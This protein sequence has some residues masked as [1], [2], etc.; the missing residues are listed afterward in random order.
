[1]A[2][3]AGTQHQVDMAEFLA[4][5][6]QVV[7]DGNIE[8]LKSPCG[9][10]DF[11]KK[12]SLSV[13]RKQS[14]AFEALRS[15]EDPHVAYYLLRWSANASRMNYLSRTTPSKYCRTALESFDCE[16]RQTFVGVSGLALDDDQWTQATFKP[17]EGG[18][19]LRSAAAVADAAYLGSRSDTHELCALIREGWTWDVDHMDSFLEQASTQVNAMLEASGSSQRCDASQPRLKQSIVGKMIETAR[20][21]SWDAAQSPDAQCRR[22]AYS[23]LHAG[24]VLG[25]TPSLTL[26]KCLSKSDFAISVACRLGV[27]VCEGDVPCNFCG[28]VMDRGGRHCL[29][30]MAGGDHTLQH[31]D[32]RNIVHSFCERA[33]LRPEREAGGILAT[34]P[35]PETR[36]RPADVLVCSSAI[37]AKTLPDGTL[38]RMPP[39]MALDFTVVNA[40][41]RGHWRETLGEAGAA[42]TSY[43]E[44]KRAYRNTA[45][46]CEEA[47]VRF[48]PIVFEAQ[49]GMTKEAAAVLHTL[50]NAVAQNENADPRKMKSDIIQRIGLALARHVASAIKR[51]RVPRPCA[52]AAACQRELERSAILTV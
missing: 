3:A 15:L 7:G 37:F 44:T 30:C 22:H 23:G 33:R 34:L 36:R 35:N 46:R 31:N 24:K 39:Q 18:L 40:L 25:V 6:C 17:R 27:D 47:G 41:G 5:G 16:V 32:V 49:G 8:V 45:Q 19:G 12:Y 4:A 28:I 38:E 2:P 50:A 21:K 20:V 42:A 43:A 9:D 14:K 26:D 51:R 29:S 52:T 11:C 10:A 13:L 48:Q 1:M